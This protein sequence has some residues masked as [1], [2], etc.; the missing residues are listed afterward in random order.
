MKIGTGSLLLFPVGRKLM[1]AAIAY[2]LGVWSSAV[3]APDWRISVLVSF[4]FL[5]FFAYR[6]RCRKEAYAFILL[7]FL[8]AGNAASAGCLSVS[9]S[10]TL[11]NT[12]F[13][14]T[15]VRIER[16]YRVELGGVEFLEGG[17][18][19][20][21]VVVTLMTEEDDPLPEMPKIGQWVSGKGRL[22]AQDEVRNPGGSDGRIRALA[23]GYELSGYL[24][25]GWTAEGEARFSLTEWFR[26]L[27][28]NLLQ[29]I[30]RLFG[31][32]APLFAA[33]MIGEKSE[34]D[35]EIT[36]AMR[37]TGIA[38]ILSVSGMHLNL[39]SEAAYVVLRLLPVGK[40]CARWLHVAVLVMFTGLTGCAVGT[41]RALLMTLMRLYAK[42]RGLRYD[43]LTA[44]SFAALVITLFSPLKAF[45][46][47]FQFSFFVVLGIALL[48]K[49]V[50]RM[51][52]MRLLSKHARPLGE[53]MT[54]A[55]A[56][57][58]AAVPMQL[59]LYGYIPLLSLP[60][61]LICG[62]IMPF[63]MT[64]GWC[65]LLI[66]TISEDL[67]VNCARMLS[68]CSSAIERLSVFAAGL[69]WGILRLP[70]PDQAL[71]LIA[72]LMMMLASSII[73]FG[74]LRR[75]A[76]AVSSAL[77]LLLYLPRFDPAP[78]YVQLDVGQSDAALIRS[79]RHAAVVDVGPE[80]SYDLLRYLRHEGLY[81]DAVILSHLD[82]DHA[83]ALSLL[84]NSEIRID[85][86]ITAK[87]A[88]ENASSIA[89]LDA[90]KALDASGAELDEVEAG[91]RLSAAGAAFDVLSPDPFLS[92][93]NE[94]SLLLHAQVGKHSL[95]L[96]GDLPQESE[97]DSVPPCD[98]LKVA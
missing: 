14:G 69:D 17:S 28:L 11:P 93:S 33:V 52:S 18:T 2:L 96:T 72:A 70:A 97:P 22:F 47:G 26:Q 8:A 30:R 63:V 50:A 65:V 61:N 91:D 90:L 29:K 49:P 86:V 31:D 45:D 68:A 20:R 48:E 21:N 60:M 12:V 27:R 73:R 19:N 42:A 7:C 84:L 80:S 39:V 3:F 16:D 87:G 85:R 94:R 88:G 74:R 55:L 58:M 1:G 5:L 34:I 6:K 66:G 41:I 35:A 82:E 9:D 79:G 54:I 89:V 25:P 15:V 71:L 81:V 67:A 95:L 56:A 23:N 59:S 24:L 57:Q 76:F 75:A 53:A 38:H 36:A 44:L 83:G 62:L 77:L 37:M 10:P 51:K 92:G 32:D 98:V 46:G 4:A 43:R 40:K 13:T 64:G 78:R